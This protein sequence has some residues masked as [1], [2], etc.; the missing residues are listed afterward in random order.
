MN[1]WIKYFSDGTKEEGSDLDVFN[2]TVSWSRGRFDSM[3]GVEVID[4]K[5]KIAI[6]GLG[7][8][9]QSDD[10]EIAILSKLLP[11]YITRRIMKKLS[12]SERIIQVLQTPNSTLL[13]P[14]D[15]YTSPS[16]I[17]YSEKLDIVPLENVGYWL[18][19]EYNIDT[20]KVHWY[21]SKEKI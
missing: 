1:G 16:A 21:Y 13:R 3:S 18:I 4:K 12:N 11:R 15:I 2:R 9:W 6:S 7:S 14:I 10:F 17:L 5:Q 20:K 8:Y 19:L